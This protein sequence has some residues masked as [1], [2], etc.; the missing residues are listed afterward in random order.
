MIVVKGPLD[1]RVLLLP[2]I[3]RGMVHH[4]WLGVCIVAMRGAGSG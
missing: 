4:V 3:L 2:L 1:L